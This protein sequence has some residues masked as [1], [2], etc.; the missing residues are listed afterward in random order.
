[1]LNFD[2]QRKE[3]FVQDQSTKDI[4]RSGHF[5]TMVSGRLVL[6]PEEALYLIDVRNAVCS[7]HKTSEQVEFNGIASAFNTSRK[8]MARYFTYKDW[9]DR[10]LVIR[11]PEGVQGNHH[12]A[13]A[14]VKKYRA[15]QLR[16]RKG[17][18]KGVFFPED[19]VT[20]SDDI[21][22]GEELYDQNWFGQF[23]TYKMKGHGKI[24]K[25]DIYETMFL[26]E[27]GTLDVSN[28]SRK[29][30]Y[31]LAM[32][33][34]ADFGKLYEVYKDWRSKGYV[35]KTGFKFGTHFRVYFPG[36]KPVR[37]SPSWVHSLHVIHVFPRDTK[38]L[39]SEWARA[40][41]LAHSVRKTF[42][43]AIPGKTRKKSISMDFDLYHRK[44]NEIETPEKG[45]PRFGMLSLSEEE[46]LGGAELSA[47]INEAKGK[48]QELII[49]IADRETAVTYYRVRR[50]ELQGSAY[51]YYEIDWMQ[52]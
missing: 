42:I 48:R 1:M 17:T 23:G 5:G 40:I 35:I 36:A 38:L 43:L 37:D 41:R 19:L 14:Q 2:S 50:I 16:L 13:T 34:R 8:F 26:M 7:D 11:S 30:I 45:R 21:E 22:K 6:L 52:P 47:I 29:R 15:D 32:K 3:A 25:Y 4:L 33:R 20:I 44:H 10:G 46:Y 18:I 27:N 31:S 51:E 28:M 39:I 9:R 12:A 24:S 49:A